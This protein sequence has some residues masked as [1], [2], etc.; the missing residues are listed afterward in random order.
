MATPSLRNDTPAKPNT[1]VNQTP[2]IFLGTE[3]F[4]D[5]GLG[6]GRKKLARPSRA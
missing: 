5:N 4:G 2:P 1:A 3:E 6:L